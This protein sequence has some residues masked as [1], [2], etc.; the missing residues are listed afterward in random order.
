MCIVEISYLIYY[1][2]IVAN[3]VLKGHNGVPWVTLGVHAA[4]GGFTVFMTSHS[5]RIPVE[6]RYV[7]CFVIL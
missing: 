2:F 1:V 7:L 5:K 6:R 3:V 4:A